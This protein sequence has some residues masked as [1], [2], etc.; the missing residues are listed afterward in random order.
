MLKDATR[1]RAAYHRY[2]VAQLG[3]DD[4]LKEWIVVDCHVRGGGGGVHQ[5]RLIVVVLVTAVIVIYKA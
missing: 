5:R 1:Q 4:L 3:I 2:I